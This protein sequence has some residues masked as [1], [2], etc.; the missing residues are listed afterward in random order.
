MTTKMTIY[1]IKRRT[2]KTEPYFFSRAT[3]FNPETNE[4]E[5]YSDES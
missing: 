4:L 5:N 1:E 3:L 2:E